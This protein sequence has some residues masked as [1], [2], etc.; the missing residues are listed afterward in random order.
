MKKLLCLSLAL[1]VCLALFSGCS[2]YESIFEGFFG[3]KREEPEGATLPTGDM[4]FYFYGNE[5]HITVSVSPD[6]STYMIVPNWGLEEA[7]EGEEKEAAEEEPE[8][9]IPATEAP[10]ATETPTVP[11]A[12]APVMPPE[13][14]D[15]AVKVWLPT[16]DPLIYEIYSAE[17]RDQYVWY[18]YHVPQIN[19]Q[20]AGAVQINQK[21]LEA[22]EEEVLEGIEAG[23][24]GY[25]TSCEGV[26]WKAH[27]YGNVLVLLTW[28]NYPGGNTYYLVFCFDT[29]TGKQLSNPE[30]LALCKV[31]PAVFVDRAKV[32]A[33]AEYCR[34]Y[35]PELRDVLGPEYY[36]SQMEK[37]M[38]DNW[39]NM[40]MKMYPAADGKLMLI[41]PIASMAGADSYQHTY[42]YVP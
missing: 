7:T 16:A 17:S 40:N 2:A 13:T 37:T 23:K 26:N 38:Q 21:I 15:P 28:D 11:S 4:E 12:A 1:A 6:G 5:E 29:V 20:A 9:D 33:Q 36:D 30:I 34:A 41:S 35:P 19:S 18:N 8:E 39:V 14:E 31:D 24:M 25:S 42:P 22:Y 27:R 32:S 3:E 10:V